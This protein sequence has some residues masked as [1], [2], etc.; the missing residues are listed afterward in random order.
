MVGTGVLQDGI[1]G[2]A[3]WG[4]DPTT[5]KVDGALDGQALTLM[6]SDVDVD[7]DVDAD[8]D[9]DGGMVEVGYR[10]LAGEMVY[11]KDALAVVELDADAIVPS[12]FAITGVYPN[13]FNNATTISYSLPEQAQVSLKLYD[14]SGREVE[15]LVD[16]VQK[17]GNYS[18]P[19]YAIDFP[20]GVYFCRLDAQNGQKVM[21]LALVR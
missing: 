21:K 17:A 9:V 16:M 19:W 20:S 4:D 1:C 5:P 12:E 14:I 6:I 8:A 10:I 7:A 15:T 11:R 18:I 2:M 13:P 3:V